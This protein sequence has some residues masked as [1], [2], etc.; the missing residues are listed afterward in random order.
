LELSPDKA[1]EKDPIV[2]AEDLEPMDPP[3]A[4]D[5]LHVGERGTEVIGE[6]RPFHRRLLFS[7]FLLLFNAD[8]SRI[9]APV[10]DTVHVVVAVLKV[11]S[12]SVCAECVLPVMVMLSSPMLLSVLLCL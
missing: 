7:G 9:Q 1:A 2:D 11:A 5:A 3:P 10:D 4:V 12:P 8:F 6:L